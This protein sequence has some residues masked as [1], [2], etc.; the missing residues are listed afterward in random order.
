MSANQLLP[1]GGLLKGVFGQL[2]LLEQLGDGNPASDLVAVKSAA[3]VVALE[4]VHTQHGI[5]AVVFFEALGR[6]QVLKRV[7]KD[8]DKL[9]GLLDNLVV[10]QRTA[11]KMLA[12]R[13]SRVFAKVQP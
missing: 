7:D 11:C 2:K 9:A 12:A 5:T 3:D 10:A 8:R 4:V 6:L 13:S 1:A